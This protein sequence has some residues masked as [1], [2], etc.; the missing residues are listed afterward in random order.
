[1]S[2][3]KLIEVCR[4]NALFDPHRDHSEYRHRFLV[5]EAR[6]AG[7]PVARRTAW[8]ICSSK[9]WFSVIGVEYRGE[10]TCPGPPV[11]GDHVGR[12]FTASVP[13]E[14]QLADITDYRTIQGKHD[15]C[16]VKDL[17]SNRIMGYSIDSRMKPG[18]AVNALNNAVARRGDVARCVLRTDRGSN[19][20]AGSTCV[21]SPGIPCSD[22]WA[23]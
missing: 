1:M 22:L 11:H 23:G 17:F 13:N 8:R 19:S 9:G 21:P 3:N 6:N 14:L 16:A 20:E 2:D 5:D 7:W 15:V 18:I 10:K 4:A 12:K